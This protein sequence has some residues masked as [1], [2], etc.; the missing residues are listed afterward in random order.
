MS[1][2]N[3]VI[4]DYTSQSYIAD[5]QIVQAACY[6]VGLYLVFTGYL[7]VIPGKPIYLINRAEFLVVFEPAGRIYR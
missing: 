1:S 7:G 4:I 2:L 3:T 6:L 5:R